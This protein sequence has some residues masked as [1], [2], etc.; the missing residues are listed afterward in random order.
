MTASKANLPYNAMLHLT[1]AWKTSDT[2]G[3]GCHFQGVLARNVAVAQRVL[4]LAILSDVGTEKICS[5]VRVN[6]LVLPLGV[7][8]G[9]GATCK[10]CMAPFIVGTN[11]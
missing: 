1:Q 6:H 2:S 4:L 11:I 3:G 10:S 9:P 8:I 7:G 5:S